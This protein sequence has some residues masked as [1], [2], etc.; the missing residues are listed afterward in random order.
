MA[1]RVLAPGPLRGAVFVSACSLTPTALA[2][3][4]KLDAEALKA[5]SLVYKYCEMPHSLMP[6]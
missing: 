4:A 1:G 3:Y 2:T 6:R 5:R